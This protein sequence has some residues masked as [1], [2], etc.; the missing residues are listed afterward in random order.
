MTNTETSKSPNLSEVPRREPLTDAKMSNLLAAVG[1]S[2]MKALLL[3]CL[4]Q[5]PYYI[6]TEADM[7]RA[8]HLSQGIL[9]GKG[10]GWPIGHRSLG[11]YCSESFAP[12][13]LVAK[14][15]T[16][17]RG[18]ETFGYQITETGNNEGLA[19]AGFLMDFA[20][21]RDTSLYR[22][23]GNTNSSTKP[24]TEGTEDEAEYKKRAPMTRIN[25]FRGLIAQSGP[26][27]QVKL[28]E[29]IGE[30]PDSLVMHLLSLGQ[31]GVITYMSLGA[32]EKIDPRGES[33]FNKYNRSKISLTEE[34]REAIS[35]L[36]LIIDMIQ[37][38]DPEAISKGKRLATI[39]LSSPDQLAEIAKK[40]REASKR[41][42]RLQTE[43]VKSAIG[44]FLIENQEQ[45]VD[46]NMVGEHI[47]LTFG[48]SV[49]RHR[50]WQILQE[51]REDK[52]IR[53]KKEGVYVKWF[54]Y[55][56]KGKK[57]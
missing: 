26:V 22:F 47:S 55:K 31:N 42:N 10:D 6:F 15:V 8:V 14:E 25:I 40:E 37:G 33:I 19:L 41:A 45:G 52:T 29:F 1:N 21:R 23:L 2:S 16:K 32:G 34:Q 12:I 5:K 50:V 54:P 53:G 20:K 13:G 4:A 46:I 57:P 39:L 51:M 9:S 24:I 27:T 56:P 43:I 18:G 11:S 7:V 38:M 48:K 3:S 30:N 36:V 49:G 17:G 44:E 35:D 28:A